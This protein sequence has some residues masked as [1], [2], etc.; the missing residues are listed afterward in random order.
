MSILSHALAQTAQL[1]TV[2]TDFHGDQVFQSQ[3][4]I[5]CR[6]RYVTELQRTNY[7]ETID[8]TDAIMWFEPNAPVQEGSILGIDGKY[9][10]VD[11]LIKARR[12]VGSNIMFLKAYMRRH[13]LATFS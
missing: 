6:F 1:V 2:T 4:T 3:Q 12:L 11:S 9:W 7:S 8:N 13:Q 10:R 5:P